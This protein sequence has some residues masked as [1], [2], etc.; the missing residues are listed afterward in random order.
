MRRPAGVIAAIALTVSSSL[1]VADAGAQCRGRAS[2]TDCFR[3]HHARA[4]HNS[5]FRYA[6]PGKGAYGHFGG[7]SG[8]FERIDKAFGAHGRS[9]NEFDYYEL[10]GRIHGLKQQVSSAV[11]RGD[12][13]GYLESNVQALEDDL[14]SRVQ[15]CK[16]EAERA[17][18]QV[19]DAVAKLEAQL[20]RSVPS[21]SG[22]DRRYFES[23]VQSLREAAESQTLEE[24]SGSLNFQLVW[25]ASQ[26]S[27]AIAS[28]AEE[29][30]LLR[31]CLQ[32]S[33]DQRQSGTTPGEAKAMTP[34][35]APGGERQAPEPALAFPRN[36]RGGAV[37]P[38][39]KPAAPPPLPVAFEK[40][41]NLLMNLHEC[42]RLGSFDMDSFTG[43]MLRLK[44]SQEKMIEK[45]GQ[46]SRRQEALIRGELALIAGDVADQ[47]GSN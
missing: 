32:Q 12:D 24:R 15:D 25:Q 33:E 38:Y 10:S 46:L 43:R 7:F 18:M 31:G 26:L 47:A 37:I 35:G 36:L 19:L 42:G 5:Y 14:A 20:D 11:A 13:P 3:L 4:A 34:P 23:Q 41:E 40:V 30:V 8:Q 16:S 27:S 22:I 2:S 17:K 21:L 9:L 44:L 39:R 29:P 1:A 45:T 28:R 6:S